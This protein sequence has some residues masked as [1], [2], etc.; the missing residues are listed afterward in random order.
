LEDKKS[1]QM[2]KIRIYLIFTLAELRLV[3]SQILGQW[4]LAPVTA[5]HKMEK[6]LCRFDFKLKASQTAIHHKF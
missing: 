4:E 5:E 1:S 2:Q 6:S 3:R